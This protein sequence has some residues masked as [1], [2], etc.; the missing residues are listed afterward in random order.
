MKSEKDILILSKE[1]TSGLHAEYYT[2]SLYLE[3]QAKF[4]TMQVVYKDQSSIESIKYIS[5][6]NDSVKITYV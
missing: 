1:R 4:S 6:D 3:I 5:L 2:Y